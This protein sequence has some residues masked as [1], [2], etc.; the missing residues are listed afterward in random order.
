M[1]G[2]KSLFEPEVQNVVIC[3]DS[4][5]TNNAAVSDCREKSS[6]KKMVAC[7][8]R[9]QQLTFS[10]DCQLLYQSSRKVS[11]SSEA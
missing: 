5:Y 9:F 8:V 10:A 3:S 7:H 1:I 11:R 2:L 4:G 6:W